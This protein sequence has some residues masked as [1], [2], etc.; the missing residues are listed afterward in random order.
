MLG[1]MMI[2]TLVSLLFLGQVL[3]QCPESATGLLR[4][5]D[6]ATWGSQGKVGIVIL[7]FTAS[8][9]FA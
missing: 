5:S 4:W 9:C 3:S 7:V 1:K 6:P 8:L 2:T